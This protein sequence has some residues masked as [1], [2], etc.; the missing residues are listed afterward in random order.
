MLGENFNFK[1]DPPN[2]VDPMTSMLFTMPDID[3]VNPIL[4]FQ[5]WMLEAAKIR[6]SPLISPISVTQCQNKYKWCGQ[7]TLNVA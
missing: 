5:Y 7:Y 2:K 4:W 3:I 6:H 1:V